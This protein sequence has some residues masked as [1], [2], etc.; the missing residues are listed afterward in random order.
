MGPDFMDRIKDYVE[1]FPNKKLPS[2]KY[3]RVPA[4]NLEN[5]F[6]WFFENFDY[7]WQTIYKATDRYVTEY[8]GRQYAYMRNSQY[9]LRKQ[10]LD[11]SFESEL[12]NYCEYI[13]SNPDD[14]IDYFKELIV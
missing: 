4:K 5:A 8:E 12:A 11:K 9:F 10:N 2:G 6:R 7:D 3:A 13:Q 1:V 14:E